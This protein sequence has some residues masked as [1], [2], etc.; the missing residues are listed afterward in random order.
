VSF[1]AVILAGGA[2]RRL[3]GADKPGLLVG[4]APMLDR[5]VEAV[6]DARTVV[7]VGPSRPLGR[8]VQ[9]CREDPPG[10]GPV[11]ALAAGLNA[12]TAERVA[13]L[14]ADLPAVGPAVGALLAALSTHPDA[15]CAALEDPGGRVNYLASTWRTRALRRALNSLDRRDGAAM[16]S[17]VAGA[18]VITVT[19]TG[20]WG[21]DCDTWDDIDAARRRADGRAP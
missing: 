8:A 17:V 6:A 5:V 15:D 19:D 14:A 16:R 1:D 9:W 2:A 7:V 11:A 20:G 4:G 10:G 21:T 13:V 12:V 3:G 18:R